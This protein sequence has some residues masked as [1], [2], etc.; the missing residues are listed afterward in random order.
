MFTER[1]ATAPPPP[2]CSILHLLCDF[3][4]H[5]IIFLGAFTSVVLPLGSSEG[6]WVGLL[7]EGLA[8]MPSPSSRGSGSYSVL[9]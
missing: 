6:A 2:P 1:L 7:A 3:L 8:G 5:F 4:V 9:P